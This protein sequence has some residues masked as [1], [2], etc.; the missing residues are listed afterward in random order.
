[1]AHFI[2]PANDTDIATKV[3]YLSTKVAIVRFSAAAKFMRSQVH[4][5][6][7]SHIVGCWFPSRPP[8]LGALTVVDALA[9]ALESQV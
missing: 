4:G 6:G 2:F 9:A 5:L 3:A 1:M 7:K 8:D